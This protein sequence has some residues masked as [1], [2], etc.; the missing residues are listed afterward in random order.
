MN[1]REFVALAAVAPLGLRATIA[2][3]PL[4]SLVT[5]DAES[6]LAVVDLRVFRVVASLPTLPDPWIR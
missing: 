2:A 3:P 5:C 4:E 1:R 6:R